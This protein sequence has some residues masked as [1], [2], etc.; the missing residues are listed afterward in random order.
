[1]EDRFSHRIPFK[2]AKSFLVILHYRQTDRMSHNINNEDSFLVD[3]FSAQCKTQQSVHLVVH[4]E[5]SLFLHIYSYCS[6]CI[7]DDAQTPYITHLS[8][9]VS[10]VEHLRCHVV[11]STTLAMHEVITARQPLHVG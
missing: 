3:N 11:E 8:I 9:L 10:G 7:H 1:M 2:Y 5:S 6:Q 4:K